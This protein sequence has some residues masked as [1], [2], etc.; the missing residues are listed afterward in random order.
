MATL[1]QKVSVKKYQK[2]YEDYKGIF[3]YL[4][5]C[6]EF[7]KIGIATGLESRVSSIQTGN[8]YEVELIWAAKLMDAIETEKALHQ[9]FAGERTFR[10]WFKLDEEDIAYICALTD[11]KYGDD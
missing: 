2:K 3:V 5:K 4:L 10:E 7:Y 9:R 6:N 11:E 8:P 1:Q